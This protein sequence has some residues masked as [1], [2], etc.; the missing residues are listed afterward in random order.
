MMSGTNG[1]LIRAVSFAAYAHSGQTRSCGA[2]PYIVHPIRVA[3]HAENAGM[4]EYA[5][6]SALLHDVLE[7]CPNPQLNRAFIKATWPDAATCIDLLTKGE[8]K[9]AYYKAILLNPAALM[10][11]LIDRADNLDEMYRMLR[12]TPRID[13]NKGNLR[14]AQSYLQKTKAEF[15]RLRATCQNEYIN[16]LFDTSL[17]KLENLLEGSEL[18]R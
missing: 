4:P 5:V 3:E 17:L 2:D 12:S 9:E 16:R 8:D 7:D 13:T 1:S 10:L 6:V 14:W 11:K 15:P 18:H